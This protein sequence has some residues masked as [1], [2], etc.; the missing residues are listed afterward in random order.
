V[1]ANSTQICGS[2]VDELVVVELKAGLTLLKQHEVQLVNYLTATGIDC[3]LLLSF[4]L[5]VH[6]KRKFRQYK[7]KPL[8]E[9]LL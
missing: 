1:L 8:S 2:M 3:G 6:V 4:G 9:S 7:A 5:S